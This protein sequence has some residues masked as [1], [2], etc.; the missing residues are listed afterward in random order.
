M[1]RSYGGLHVIYIAHLQDIKSWSYKDNAT[2]RYCCVIASSV[3]LNLIWHSKTPY[4]FFKKI[5]MG[6]FGCIN[7]IKSLA[8]SQK[9]ILFNFSLLLIS[10]YYYVFTPKERI[11]RVVWLNYKCMT[12]SFWRWVGL[13]LWN[14]YVGLSSYI[15][16][17]VDIEKTCGSSL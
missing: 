16:I 17:I 3:F 15:I 6:A 10:G 14:R 7:L 11:F 4:R 13:W 1:R 5:F 9:L 12:K 8:S 2:S